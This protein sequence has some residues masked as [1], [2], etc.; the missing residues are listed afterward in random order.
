MPPAVTVVLFRCKDAAVQS[1]VNAQLMLPVGR[2]SW[3]HD[4]RRSPGITRDDREM[5][6]MARIF[7][8]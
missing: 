8:K 5:L 6:P 7:N 4:L 2:Q 3:S 1:P